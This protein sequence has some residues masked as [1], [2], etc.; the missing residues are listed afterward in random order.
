MK[1]PRPS[2]SNVVA[3]LCLFIVLGGASY[4]A[5]KVPKKSVGTKQLKKE[6]VTGDK[7]A[8]AAISEQHIAPGTLAKLVNQEIAER[9]PHVASATVDA[10]GT[11]IGGKDALSATIISAPFNTYGVTFGRSLSGCALVAT[12]AG[13]ATNETLAVEIGADPT[14]ARIDADN[15][16]GFHLQAIC[17]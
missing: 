14:L 16:S 13:G 2:Y 17:Q 7:I 10:A 15:P 9:D 3:T 12:P 5:M 11:L 8:R 6:A 1:L 4:A